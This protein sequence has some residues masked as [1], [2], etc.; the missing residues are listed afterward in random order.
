MPRTLCLAVVAALLPSLVHAAD[1][2]EF[3]GPTGQG[4]AE[5]ALPLEW[6]PDKNITWKH[7]IDGTGW[8]SP[9]IA[10]GKIFLTTAVPVPKAKDDLS[11]RALCLDAK[12]GNSLWDVELFVE[13][14]SKVKIHGKNSH[15]SPT[16][17]IEGDR[18]YVHFG[19][20]GTACLDLDGKVQWR[21]TISYRPVHGNGG[22]PVVVDDLLIFSCDGND[23]Q[24][25]VA[26]KKK[27]GEE[28]WRTDRKATST[29]KFSFSTPL[30]ITVDG[31]K[32]LV[33]PGPSAVVAYNPKNGEEIWRV[34]YGEG[35]SVVP[36]P[37]FA[38]G[39]VFVSSG[40]DNATFYAIKPGKGDVTESNVVWKLTKG[41][42]HNPSPLV[43]GDELYLLADNGIATC[44]DAKTGTVHWQERAFTKDCSSSPLCA[45]GKVYFQ[46]EDGSAVVVKAGTK[47]ERLAKNTLEER[48]LASYAAV[49][50]ALFLRTEKNLYRIEAR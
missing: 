25:V 31:Q 7:A 48:T 17:V 14:G 13:D 11:L 27:T 2:P 30:L 9:A 34:R 35:Y 22:S 47:F 49:D 43:V 32:Q 42:P 37:V 45:D 50:G 15:A 18:V 19:H 21:K 23:K 12:T 38:H 16:A 26:L 36:R 40:Y 44:V 46:A 4:L 3:R 8:S 10:G 29:K 20:M 28:A 39:L 24:V 1:W 41:A 5:G 33:S 6:G